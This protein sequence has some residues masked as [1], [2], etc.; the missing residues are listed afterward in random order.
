LGHSPYLS[1]QLFLR[2]SLNKSSGLDAI[3]QIPKGRLQEQQ[4]Q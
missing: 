3:K 1:L 4:G 2:G